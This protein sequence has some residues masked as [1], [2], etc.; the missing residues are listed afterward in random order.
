MEKITVK[1]V[2]GYKNRGQAREQDFRF[3]YN[4]TMEKA[5]NKKATVCADI[6]D[7]QIKSARA[8]IC[9]GLDVD[10]YLAQDKANRYAYVTKNETAYIMTKKE[11]AEFAK[12]FHT[13]TRESTKNGGATKMR[14]LDENQKM[15]AWLE[16]HV[17]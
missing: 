13:V 6:D 7:I 10:G 4:K 15:V 5:D 14:F 16:S 11:Y 2:S 9:Q 3:A 1:Q 17:A 8:T 12:R